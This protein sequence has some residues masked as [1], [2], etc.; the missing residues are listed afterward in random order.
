MDVAEI[1][2]QHR[3]QRIDG[4]AAVV[5]TFWRR[6]GPSPNAHN[7]GNTIEGIWTDAS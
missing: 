7:R 1:G 4:T 2:G 3:Q 5:E 6:W